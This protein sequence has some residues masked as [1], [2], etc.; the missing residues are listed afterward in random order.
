MPAELDAV[1]SFKSKDFNVYQARLKATWAD[2]R[3][4]SAVSHMDNTTKVAENIA[5]AKSPV[6]LSA[7]EYKQLQQIAAATAPYHC[8]GCAQH[9]EA[10]VEGPV[11]IADSLRFLMYEEAYGDP[12]KARELYRGLPEAAKAIEGVDFRA[13]MDACPQG[14]DIASRLA[15]AKQRLA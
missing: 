6:Q 2:E 4:D 8:Q 1:K 15:V 3:I 14:I 7:A 13:A 5:A 11:A 12:Q 9:C 10:R